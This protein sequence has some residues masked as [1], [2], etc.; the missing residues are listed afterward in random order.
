MTNSNSRFSRILGLRNLSVNERLSKIAEAASLTP[1]QAVNLSGKGILADHIADGMTENVIGKFEIPL[2]V[3]TNFTINQK[4][5][6]IPMAVEE[7][8]VVAAASNMARLARNVGGFKAQA[9]RPIMRA[10]IQILG[11]NDPYAALHKVM[12]SRDGLIAEANACDTLLVG[13]GGGCLDI[14]GHVFSESPIGSMLVLHL[15]V[16]V[17]DAMGANT[18]NTMAEA[19]APQIETITGGEVRLKI[20]GAVLDN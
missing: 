8:S 11:L 2:G 17:R 5:Y 4:D 6:L 16:D 1:E 15:L 9:A 18:V 13:L 19:L 10:Q 14:E 3:A 12:L 7:P 20:L